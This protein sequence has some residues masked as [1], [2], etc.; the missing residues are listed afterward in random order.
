MRINGGRRGVLHRRRGA[1]HLGCGGADREA[2]GLSLAARPEEDKGRRAPVVRER[3][4]GA[5]LVGL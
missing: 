3:R 4:G 1:W 5:G 2:A